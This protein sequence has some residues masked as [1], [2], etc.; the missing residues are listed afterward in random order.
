MDPLIYAPVAIALIVA[1]LYISNKTWP[2]NNWFGIVPMPKCQRCGTP[3]PRFPF[4][5]PTLKEYVTGGWHCRKCG[6]HVDKNG[7]PAAS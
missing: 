2:K 4:I 5:K 6:A 7:R 3:K 1:F